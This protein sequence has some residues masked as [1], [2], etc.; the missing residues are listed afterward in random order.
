MLFLQILLNQVQKP[1]AYMF[2]GPPYNCFFSLFS[3]T[4]VLDEDFR[5]QSGS[6]PARKASAVKG[7]SK[8][9]VVL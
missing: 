7:L 5:N 8:T 4:L 1:R 6:V 2:F 3:E 9:V